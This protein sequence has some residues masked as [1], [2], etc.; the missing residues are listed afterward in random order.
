MLEAASQGPQGH[1]YP[2]RVQW[3]DTDAAGIVYYANYLRFVERG[4]SDVLLAQGVNQDELLRRENLAFA[5]RACAI[6]YLKPARLHEDLVV[7]TQLKAA[8]GATLVLDQAVWR[9]AEK[10]AEAVVTLACIDL[11]GRPKRIPKA[12]S[13][14]FATLSTNS[15]QSSGTRTEKE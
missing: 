1:L 9:Q 14:L 13:G 8:R 3:E 5:V 2:L 6:E 12:I 10:L 11:G 15:S 4:R 7:A